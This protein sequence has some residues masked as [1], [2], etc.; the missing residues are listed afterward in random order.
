MANENKLFSYDFNGDG[1][2][3]FVMV[4]FYQAA[5]MP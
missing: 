2:G 4:H 1:P 3:R 5:M